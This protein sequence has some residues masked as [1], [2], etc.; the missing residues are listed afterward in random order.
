MGCIARLGC[1]V[2]LALLACIGWFTRSLWLPERFRPAA[3][4]VS[5]RW[6]P[7]TPAGAER[8]RAAITRLSQ[9]QGPVF[10][11]IAAGDLASLAAAEIAARAGGSADS[12]AARV[13]GDRLTTRARVDFTA[14]RGKLGP[15]GSMLGDRAMVELSGGF[16]MLRPGV[17]EFEVQSAKVGQ[18]A[19]PPAMIPRLIQEI[20][21]GARPAGMRADALPLPVPPYI[22]DIRIANGKVTLYKNVK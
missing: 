2:L 22:G 19:L 5:G 3:A 15:L 9:P 17:G 20:D 10:E 1:L 14:V 11:S 12:V 18:V 21:H 16:H 4:V 13:D 6:Q 7:A 8:A